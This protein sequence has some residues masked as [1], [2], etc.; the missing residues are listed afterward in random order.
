MSMPNFTWEAGRLLGYVGRVAIAIRMNTPYN[1]AYDPRAP[2]HAD[3][4]MWLADSLHH[5]ERLG[6]ALQES[7]LQIIED[8]CNTLLAIYKD[9][10]RSDTGMKPEPAATFQRQTA[11][12]LNEGR[13]IL[14]ELRDKA[15]ALRDQEQDQDL[16]R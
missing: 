3:D 14:T 1:G 6:H 11:F 2:H 10:G 5:F 4:V 9:Y 13:A 7:N 8:T 12:R 15:R 16:E